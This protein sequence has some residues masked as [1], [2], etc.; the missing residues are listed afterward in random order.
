MTVKWRDTSADGDKKKVGFQIH[1]A[2]GSILI[3]EAHNN[4][5]DLEFDA[6]AFKKGESA[7]T[8]GKMMAG[9]I[10]ADALASVKATGVGFHDAMDLAP[11]QYTVRFVVRDNLTGKIGSVSAPLTVN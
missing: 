3:E 2:G 4:H 8:F 5:F 6:V 11:G 10:N 7:G 1:L 9:S